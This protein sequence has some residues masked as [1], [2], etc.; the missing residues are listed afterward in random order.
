MFGLQDEVVARGGATLE[1][2]E[3]PGHRRRRR[4][5]RVRIVERQIVDDIDQHR[6]RP[7]DDW[8][9]L[10]RCTSPRSRPARLPASGLRR[11]L[12]CFSGNSDWFLVLLT[13][14]LI[15]VRRVSRTLID[16][17]FGQP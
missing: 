14:V 13:L 9:G 7:R 16:P 1:M 4:D 10:L 12:A 5:D 15:R 11:A 17:A 8:N 3:W 6:R 2:R